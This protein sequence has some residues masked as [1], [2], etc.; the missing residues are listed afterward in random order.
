MS[1]LL[2]RTLIRIR[3]THLPTTDE[4][5]DALEQGRERP[6]SR[7]KDRNVPSVSRRS[8]RSPKM[9]SDNSV[10][11]WWLIGAMSIVDPRRPVL[12][13]QVAKEPAPLE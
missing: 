1:L 12:R 8:S 13:L 2:A 9:R 10:D 6:G 5:L 7:S 11:R 4:I 3:R